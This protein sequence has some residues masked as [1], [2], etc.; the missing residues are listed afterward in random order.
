MVV[1]VT[2]KS[3]MAVSSAS[4]GRNSKI[5]ASFDLSELKAQTYCASRYSTLPLLP[6]TSGHM[7]ALLLFEFTASGK[8]DATLDSFVA[9]TI[10][11]HVRVLRHY[12]F[13]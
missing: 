4:S 12:L 1:V 9:T 2:L 11:M 6:A 13:I 5:I 10:T 7:S 3:K 8:Y